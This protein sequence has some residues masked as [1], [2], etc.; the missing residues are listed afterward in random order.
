M[1]FS[2]GTSS[3]GITLVKVDVPNIA[4]NGNILTASTSVDIATHLT[5]TQTTTAITAV[6]LNPT[7]TTVNKNIILQ[8]LSTS[9]Q[10]ITISCVGGDS[11][12]IGV[13]QSTEVTW[14]GTAWKLLNPTQVFPEYVEVLFNVT[15]TAVSASDHVKYNTI[16]RRLGNSITPDISTTYTTTANVN[17]LG[18]FTLQPNKTYELEGDIGDTSGAINSYINYRWWNSDTNTEITSGTGGSNIIGAILSNTNA[19]R[20]VAKT[21]FTPTIATRVELRFQ[22]IS[23]VT[24]YGGSFAANRPT[25]RIQVIS[26]NSPVS[27]QSVDA[28]SI[29]KSLA[30]AT[31]P[32]IQLLT[33]ANGN[34][35]LSVI[36]TGNALNLS[37]LAPTVTKNTGAFTMTT[38]GLICIKAGTYQINYSV[39]VNVTNVGNIIGVFGTKNNVFST[40]YGISISQ[41]GQVINRP[42]LNA[43]SFIIDVIAGDTVQLQITE[44]NNATTTCYVTSYSLDVV[45]VGTTATLANISLNIADLPTGGA[46]QVSAIDPYVLGFNVT[47]TTVSQSLSIPNPSST[48]I[49]RVIYINNTGTVSF[50]VQGFTISVGQS[51]GFIWN[52][53]AWSNFTNNTNQNV[54]SEYGEQILTALSSSS[55]FTTIPN[56]TFVIPSAGTWNIGYNIYYTPTEINESVQYRLINVTGGNTVVTGSLSAIANAG[57]TGHIDQTTTQNVVITTTGATT[58]AIQGLS[59]GSVEVLWSTGVPI[60]NSKV[61]W[62]K[63]GGFLPITGGTTVDTISV[64]L[65]GS[66]FSVPATNTDVLFNTLA[67]GSGIPYNSSTGVFTLTANKTYELE[68]TLK[69]RAIVAGYVQYE[70]VDATS[71]VSITGCTNGVDFHMP[72]TL[73]EGISARAYLMYTPATNQT[74]KVRV[75][76]L[77]G[78]TVQLDAQRCN[79]N[80]KQIGS[81]ATTTTTRALFRGFNTASQVV[82]SGVTTIVTINSET[83]DTTNSFSANTFTCPRTGFYRVYGRGYASGVAFVVSTDQDLGIYKNGAVY[84]LGLSEGNGTSGELPMTVYALVQCNAGDT[85]DLRVRI[86][87]TTPS[88]NIPTSYGEFSI[89]EVSTAF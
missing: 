26:G 5:F 32:A 62:Q 41:M 77:S 66:N 36:T 75:T 34:Q 87:N 53:T 23:G 6:L 45:Q 39:G 48:T 59:V 56:G 81:S 25:A 43:G 54:L 9:T 57:V 63:I 42:N 33:V 29:N 22:T 55:S 12:T 68:C 21:T 10:P 50:T 16:V 40:K 11:F 72:N 13:G 18:R 83:F 49:N 35:D 38:T 14:N 30:W 69:S 17:S 84:A 67:F 76:G 85:L 28:L 78:T 61:Y 89:E 24:T 60:A 58:F 51:Q 27:G 8:N 71:G 47:Q 88:F 44:L 65:T 64:N 74:V 46:I 3:S 2:G 82:T 1:P 52:G 86:T 79:A 20:S 4:S 31:S 37:T 70:W 80:I 73:V 15:D 7:I 19:G